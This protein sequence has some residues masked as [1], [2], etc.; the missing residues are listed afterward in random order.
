MGLSA[1]NMHNNWLPKPENELYELLLAQ[2][3]NFKVSKEVVLNVCLKM[4]SSIC[5]IEHLRIRKKL[6]RS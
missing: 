1:K 2:I 3:P 5:L 4:G 6:V